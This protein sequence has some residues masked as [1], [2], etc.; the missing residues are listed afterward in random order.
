MQQPGWIS[1]ELCRVNKTN[2]KMLHAVCF[3]LYNILEIASY[4]YGEVSGHQWLKRGWCGI[5]CN[6]RRM[7]SIR[8]VL[9]PDC[10]SISKLVVM[11]QDVTIGRNWVHRSFCIIFYSCM[12]MYNY[13]KMKSLMKNKK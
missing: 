5:K 2:P 13:L 7:C 11:L 1:R 9:Y 8:N 6:M 10:I 12:W 4:N 3:H